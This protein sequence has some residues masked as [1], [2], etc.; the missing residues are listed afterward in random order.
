[1]AQTQAGA[2]ASGEMLDTTL[3]RYCV[4]CHNDRARTAGLTLADVNSREV[5]GQA[6]TFEKVLH[7]IRSG[8]MPPAG[9]PAPDAATA[10]NLVGWLTTELDR[11][12]SERPNPG[13]PAIHRLNRA[14]YRNAVRDLLRLDLDHARDL[15]ADDSGY[16]FD[17]IG[18]VLTVSPLHIEKYI[19]AARR[20]SRQAVGTVTPRPVVEK[21]T[22]PRGQVDEAIDRLPPNE[23]GGTLFHHYFPFDAEYSILV[24]VRGRRAPGMP[25]PRLDV[26]ID[27][28]RIRL[29]DADFDGEEANQGTREFEVRLPVTAG[30]HEIAAGFLTEYARSE[31][32]DTRGVNDFSVDYVLVGGPYDAAG[33]GDTASRRRIFVCRPAYGEPEEPCA[34]RIVTDLARQAYRRP[35]S[36]ADIDPL[37]DLFALGRGD[38]ASFEAGIEMALSGV[39]V[40]PSF[41]FR[42]PSAP[43]GGAPGSVYPLSDID[44]ASRLSFFLWSSIPDDELLRL[45]EQGRLSEPRTL[46]AQLARMLADV[47]ASALVENFGGQWLHLRN[48]ADWTPDPERFPE[49]DESLRYAFQRETELFLEHLIRDDGS[50]MDLIDADYT[51][52]NERLADFYGIDDVEGGYFRRVPLAGTERRGIVTHGSVLMVTSYPTRTSPVLRGK[53]VLENLLGAPPPPPPPDVP[54]L[55]NDAEQSAGNL[56]EALEQHRANPACA[57]CHSRLDPLGFALENFDAVGAFRTEDDGVAVEASGALP[58]GTL[59]DGPLGLR[60]VLLARRDEFVEALADRLLTYALGRGLESYDRPAVREIRRRTE[61]EDYRFSALVEAIVDSVPFRMRRIPES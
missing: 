15:P 43:A 61:S 18:D 47:K 29:F 5:A 51:F 14:E 20:I 12:A 34:R 49:F 19:A 7:K 11:V 27:G 39:L 38:G 46:A 6:A 33:P 40:S 45:A 59:L 42:A 16:G 28:R 1:M 10:A 9:R 58:D 37:L 32:T 41:V 13:A 60:D 55:A 48:V 56:R 3:T 26:R 53:W 35:V 2:A 8:E 21:Y 44:L 17:N 22:A 36:A 52:L 57:V 24:R 25:A 30:D 54:V 4:S 23:R 50:V 31:G